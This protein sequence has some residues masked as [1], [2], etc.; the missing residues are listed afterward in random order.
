[1][2]TP[3]AADDFTIIRAR[4]E[5][6][7]RERADVTVDDEPRRPEERPRPYTAGRPSLPNNVGFPSVIIRRLSG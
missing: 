1:M 3:R 4:M 2:T 7:R 6:L 5:E